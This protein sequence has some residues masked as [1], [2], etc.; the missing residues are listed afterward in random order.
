MPPRYAYWTIILEGKPT[1]FR[2]HT[3]EEL[4]PSFKQLQ[5]R[6]DDI[7]MMWFARGRLWPSQEEE[8]A[9][10][11]RK[12]S[13]ERR[14][15]GWRPGGTQEDPRGSFKAPRD[16]RRRGFAGKIR[17]DRQE[18]GGP[19]DFPEPREPKPAGGG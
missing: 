8:R 9:A 19:P 11:R 10:A 13:G 1:A 3:Q 2:A 18:E 12:P 4:M 15:R 7:A 6:H 14:G 17:R 5:T 16:E